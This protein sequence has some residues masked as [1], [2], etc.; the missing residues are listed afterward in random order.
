[1][2]H[3][4]LAGAAAVL[5]WTMMDP[6]VSDLQDTFGKGFLYHPFALWLC[7][8]MIVHTQTNDFKAGVL[9]VVGYELL[10]VVWRSFKPEP[11][12]V[13][14]LRKLLHR[15]QNNHSLSDADVDFLNDITP[16]DVAVSRQVQQPPVHT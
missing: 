13:G 7:I 2:N 9:V 8:V 10:K 3:S 14:N 16:R 11:P 15:V 12:A 4:V 5:A 1:M 6:L